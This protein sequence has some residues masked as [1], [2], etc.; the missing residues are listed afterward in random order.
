MD[1]KLA[2]FSIPLKSIPLIVL[3]PVAADFPTTSGNRMQAPFAASLPT[4]QPVVQ[5]GA[6]ATAQPAV[7][8]TLQAYNAQK[9]SGTCPCFQ[10]FWHLNLIENS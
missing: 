1:Y 2:W 7:A 10:L 6:Q 9:R 4:V 3:F 5:A 8:A